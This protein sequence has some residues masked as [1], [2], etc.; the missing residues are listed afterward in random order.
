MRHIPRR[1]LVRAPFKIPGWSVGYNSE[2]SAHAAT[3]SAIG[4]GKFLFVMTTP[5]DREPRSLDEEVTVGLYWL[6]QDGDWEQLAYQDFPDVASV[7][8]LSPAELQ[9]IIEHALSLDEARR[10]LVDELTDWENGYGSDVDAEGEDTPEWA[11]GI[12]KDSGVS[13][14][15][16]S[17][18]DAASEAIE[19][20]LNASGLQIL[21][22]MNTRAEIVN[23]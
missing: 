17:V 23:A 14:E 22:Y 6:N 21:E 7:I 18:S 3:R 15:D 20:V 10:L 8:K 13:P 19:Q 11:A 5:E 2:I 1:T 16:N 4:N 12:F 9:L